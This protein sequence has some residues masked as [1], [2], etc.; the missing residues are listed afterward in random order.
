MK[1]KSFFSVLLLVLFIVVGTSKGFCQFQGYTCNYFARMHATCAVPAVDEG[2]LTHSDSMELKYWD[3]FEEEECEE[4]ELIIAE[5]MSQILGLDKDSIIFY[6]EED[7]FQVNENNDTITAT[8]EEDGEIFEIIID[9]NELIY[10][11]RYYGKENNPF[12]GNG[13]DSSKLIQVDRVVCKTVD[14][15]IIPESYTYVWYDELPSGIP[16]EV[17]FITTYLYYER[18]DKDGNTLVKTGNEQLYLDCI[19]D[20]DDDDDNSITKIQQPINI[21]VYPNPVNY[22]LRI[23]NYEGGEVEILDV[24]GRTLLSL[25]TLSSPETTI[26]VSHLTSGMYFLKT[27]NKTVKFVKE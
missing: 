18:I 12:F 15:H 27:G 6:L 25:R 9:L 8:Y 13:D 2:N 24:V 21:A 23:T 22:E 5:V 1:S 16:Y 10:E 4:E 11:E 19:D 17:S 26:D 14:G 7:E 20:D 3:I